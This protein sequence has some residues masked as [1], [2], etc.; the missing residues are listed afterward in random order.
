[1]SWRCF[2]T[3]DLPKDLRRDPTDVPALDTGVAGGCS[4]LVCID[5]DLRYASNSE[6]S[7]Y[8]PGR[9][10]AVHIE[11]RLNFRSQA[12]ISEAR[13]AAKPTI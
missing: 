9:V 1:L 6:S 4:L 11:D 5:R 12:V 13:F 3:A 8:S 10:W 2:S 7:D